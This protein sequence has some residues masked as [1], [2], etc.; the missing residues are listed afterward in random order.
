MPQD[1]LQWTSKH[2]AKEV[3]VLTDFR[4]AVPLAASRASNESLE[5]SS[6]QLIPHCL[7]RLSP[8]DLECAIVCSEGVAPSSVTL[9]YVA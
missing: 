3:E 4:N 7:R 8:W 5:S 6:D 9:S 2:A 1:R